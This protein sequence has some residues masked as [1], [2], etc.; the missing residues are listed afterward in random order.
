[1]KLTKVATITGWLML[2]SAYI[3]SVSD[4]VYSITNL[5][6]IVL[7]VTGF[8]TVFVSFRYSRRPGNQGS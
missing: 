2:A 4:Y 8:L 5:T 6:P 1:M 3:W 7:G